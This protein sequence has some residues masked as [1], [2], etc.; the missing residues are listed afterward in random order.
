MAIIKNFQGFENKED[1]L[2]LIDKFDNS[3][4]FEL[5]ISIVN[6]K[7][8]PA[9]SEVRIKMMKLAAGTKKEEYWDTHTD[10][11]ETDDDVSPKE[12]VI[13]MSKE[14][15]K[16]SGEVIKAPLV[17]TFYSSSSPDSEPYV[18]VGDKVTKGMIVC[19][20]EAMKIM[21][22]IESEADGEVAEVL[23]KNASAVEY[24]QPL[25]RLK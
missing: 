6:N 16:G 24:G 22:E 25:F 13:K 17:G 11:D 8:P 12:T 5:D 1:I 14:E 7:I 10:T 2:E 19:I 23:V 3:S 9:E 4:L 18:K 15:P 21:N 20:I